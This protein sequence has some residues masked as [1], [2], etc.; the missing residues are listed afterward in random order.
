MASSEWIDVRGG[1]EANDI[2]VFND[3][4]QAVEGKQ[5]LDALDRIEKGASGAA[6]R[7]AVVVG[8]D[9]RLQL[10]L[11]SLPSPANLLTGKPMLNG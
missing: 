2:L 7:W 1:V 11:Q 3:D 5:L 6:L 8:E 9:R 4:K 10:Q